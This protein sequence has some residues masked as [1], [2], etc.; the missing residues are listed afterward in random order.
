M[1]RMAHEMPTGVV[2]PDL[3]KLHLFLGLWAGWRNEG[4]IALRS[5][6]PSLP[7][8]L[9]GELQSLHWLTFVSVIRILKLIYPSVDDKAEEGRRVC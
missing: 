2:G 3:A 4:I 5:H 9:E 6:M 1:V 8:T 7:D